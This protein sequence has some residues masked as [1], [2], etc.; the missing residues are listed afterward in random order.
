MADSRAHAAEVYKIKAQV[1]EAHDTIE[2]LRRENKNL[3]GEVREQPVGQDSN[4][5]QISQQVTVC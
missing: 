5:D 1:D 2:A 4:R 3:S